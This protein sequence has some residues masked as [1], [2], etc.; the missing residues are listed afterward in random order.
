[1]CVVQASLRLEAAIV[2]P[3]NQPVFECHSRSARIEIAMPCDD[4]HFSSTASLTYQYPKVAV[5]VERCAQCN[6]PSH[7]SVSCLYPS[8]CGGCFS[9]VEAAALMS[10]CCIVLVC[11]HLDVFIRKWLVEHLDEIRK[12]KRIF[13]W[14]PSKLQDTFT[15]SS[16]SMTNAVTNLEQ[17]QAIVCRKSKKHGP[18]SIL[19]LHVNTCVCMLL[20]YL[21]VCV[22]SKSIKSVASM[23]S[24]R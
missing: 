23:H 2:N 17:V 7:I 18:S 14:R 11:Q 15:A 8:Q 3:V 20:H 24:S 19:L 9:V 5:R 1:M 21:N 22:A 4:P 10:G 12:R 16:A 6:V 13:R